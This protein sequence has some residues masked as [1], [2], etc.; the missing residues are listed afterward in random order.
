MT[1][2]LRGPRAARGS[3]RLWQFGVGTPGMGPGLAPL[4]GGGGGAAG[5]G[6]AAG[7]A[8][9]FGVSEMDEA[10]HDGGGE[11]EARARV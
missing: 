5:I 11:T 4:G 6:E 7:W 10:R 2:G 8:G 9:D 1:P 3:L